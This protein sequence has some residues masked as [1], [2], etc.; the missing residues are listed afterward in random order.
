V[1][2]L[3]LL[4]KLQSY[5]IWNTICPFNQKPRNQSTRRIVLA[6]DSRNQNVHSPKR[7]IWNPKLIL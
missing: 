4:L 7:N 1:L 6:K 3:T 5:F 2:L